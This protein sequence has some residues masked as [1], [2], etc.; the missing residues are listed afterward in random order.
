MIK[1]NKLENAKLK[2]LNHIARAIENLNKAIGLGERY[3]NLGINNGALAG[4][5]YEV[6]LIYLQQARIE[7]DTE[8]R[9]I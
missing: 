7:L 4:L 6:S 9:S 1:M 5:S 2:Q 3:E 8:D